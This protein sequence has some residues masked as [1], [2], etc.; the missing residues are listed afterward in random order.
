MQHIV[1][2]KG[3]KERFDER[4]VY[5]SCYAACLSTHMQH[6]EA[7]KICRKVTSEVKKWITK[8]KVVTSHQIFLQVASTIK[9]HHKN[10]AFMYATHR[11]IS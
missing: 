8:K 9:K 6:Q 11:D 4:K 2:R 3:N 7:E 5:A 1:K 10:A